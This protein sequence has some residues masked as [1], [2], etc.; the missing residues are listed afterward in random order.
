MKRRAVWVASVALALALSAAVPAAVAAPAA[1]AELREPARPDIAPPGYEQT[2]SSVTRT[3]AA[4]PAVRA[5]RAAHRPAYS[6]AYLSGPR[7]WQVSFYVPPQKGAGTRS[8]QIAQVIV[9]DRTGR[10]LETWTGPQVE[11]TMARGIP[12]QFGRAVNAPWVW[13][14]L[15]VLFALPFLRRPV[16]LLHLDL[17]VLL[18]FSVSYAFFGTGNLDV[19]VPSAYPLLAY[20]LGRMLW[21]AFRPPVAREDMRLAVPAGFLLLGLVFLIGFRL[22]L[23]V[24]NGNVIDVGYAGV[25]GGDRLLHGEALYGAF[26][27]DNEFGDT[28]GP[29]AYAAYVP[30]V[31]LFGW[32]GS[33]D[34]LP[35]AHGAAVAF[36]VACLCG[37]WLAGRRIGGSTL[38][39]LL[40]YLWA[41]CP[42]TL[43]VANSGANDALVAALVLAAFVCL[44]RPAARGATITLAGLTKFAPLALAPLFVAYRG[45]R[46]RSIAAAAIAGVL[47]LAPVALG[48]GGLERFWDRTLGFQA[49]RSSPFSIWGLYGGLD[50]LQVAL[51]VAAAALAVAVAFVPRQRDQI[52]IAALGAGVLIAVQLTVTHWFYLYVVWFLPL[53]LIALLG[54]AEVTAPD[55]GSA[56]S[57]RPGRPVHSG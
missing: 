54:R 35:A 43:L 6:R 2:A 33:W 47:V 49:G 5:A 32:G 51:T 20:L 38:G 9:D 29:L 13:I 41:A 18:G 56:R 24:T 19:S 50:A 52:T 40:A 23:N 16:R 8:E 26:P 15:C 42:F 46:V 11:W 27:A 12:G 39:L 37:M 53:L 55:A 3:A 34:D 36:D 22:V 28:Y 45:G 44:D 31:L 1:P 48:P 25:I 17:A 14:G 4:Q 10:V 21:L 30:F 57:T 7:R